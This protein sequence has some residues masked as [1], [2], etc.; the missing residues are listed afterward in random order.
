M[1]GWIKLHR[2]LG[3]SELWLSEPFT[4]GQAWVD[5]IMLAN[6]KDGYIRV[7]GIKIPV[8][9]GQVGWSQL[10][11][12][13]RWKW[14][15]PKVRRFLDEL[16]LEKNILQQTIQQNMR[17]TTLFNI[18]NYELYQTD[19]TID[20]TTEKQQTLHQKNIRTYS[21]KKDKKDKNVKKGKK[22]NMY[23]PENG[24]PYQEIIQDLN[25]K[26]S[27]NYKSTTPKTRALIKARFKEGF[28]L[29]D[30][31]SVHTNQTDEW[32]GTDMAKYLRPETLYGTKFESYLNQPK[33]TQRLSKTLSHNV[34][35][36]KGMFKNGKTEPKRVG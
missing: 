32:I 6:F 1:S 34:K 8:K 36:V 3:D 7:R 15:R 26:A 18:I 9:R 13:K 17:I 33:Q 35:V 21:N 10:S 23:I 22:R 11:L 30:F 27:L 16:I 28:T 19:V 14:S 25:Q 24:V 5:L 2:R 12:A 20:D 31:I 29:D 4:R